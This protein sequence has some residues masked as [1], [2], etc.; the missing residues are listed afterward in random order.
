MTWWQ[1]LRS[2]QSQC[3]RRTHTEQTGVRT[4]NELRNL[5]TTGSEEAIKLWV[6]PAGS[7]NA[8]GTKF[9]SERRTKKTCS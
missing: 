1:I 3:T 6:S 9:R 4:V 8:K 5:S 7:A 2:Q